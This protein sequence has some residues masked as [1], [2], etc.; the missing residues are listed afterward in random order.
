M[1]AACEGVVEKDSAYTFDND[2]K[3]TKSQWYLYYLMALK[4]EQISF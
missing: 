3:P 2:G 1:A 4:I